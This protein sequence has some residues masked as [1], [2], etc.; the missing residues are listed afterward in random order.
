MLLL[1]I[2][3]IICFNIHYSESITTFSILIIIF[4]E[5]V[6]IFNSEDR[7]TNSEFSFWHEAVV[8]WCPSRR[9]SWLC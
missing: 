8:L 2:T 4:S 3:R 9:H 1:L 7:A 6:F 5:K